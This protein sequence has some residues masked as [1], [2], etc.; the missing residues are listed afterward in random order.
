MSDGISYV[1]RLALGQKD[2]CLPHLPWDSS[3]MGKRTRLKP[4][5]MPFLKKML[6]RLG[7]KLA[8]AP[9]ELVPSSHPGLF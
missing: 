7:A 1:S 3:D 4:A 8:A 5:R 9:D 2:A 6:K